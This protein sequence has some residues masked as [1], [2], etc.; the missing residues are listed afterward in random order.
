MST[1]EERMRAL[2][3]VQVV[4]LSRVLGDA[5]EGITGWCRD[6]DETALEK[7]LAS[8]RHMVRETKKLR[9][10]P[11]LRPTQKEIRAA[12]R[13]CGKMARLIE[14]GVEKRSGRLLK[15]AARLM[16]KGKAHLDRATELMES[17][18]AT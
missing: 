6:R 18:A 15:R 3:V 13:A 12:T 5:V 1:R 7:H 8:I 17:L 9:P 14:R 10:P 11:D 16:V 2:Y 4:A